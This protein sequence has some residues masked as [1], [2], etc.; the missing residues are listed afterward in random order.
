MN[1]CRPS[2]RGGEVLGGHV[3]LPPTTSGYSNITRPV[4]LC[5]GTATKEFRVVFVLLIR[6]FELFLTFTLQILDSYW[7]F[8]RTGGQSS[9][10]GALQ[11]A[12]SWKQKNNDVTV[13]PLHR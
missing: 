13:I 4:W 10:L 5:E 2:F 1:L 11:K 6:G 9:I 12:V 8:V 7:G 3:H